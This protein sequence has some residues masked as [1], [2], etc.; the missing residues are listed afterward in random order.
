[1][2]KKSSKHAEKQTTKPET[3]LKPFFFFFFFTNTIMD[4]DNQLDDTD[5]CNSILSRFS[6]STDPQHHHLCSIIG[7]ISQTLKDLNHPLTP[8]AYFGATCTS[9]NKLLSSDPKPPSHHIDALVTIIS[10][11]L[12][13]IS[14]A[15]VRKEA[16]YVS[17]LITRVV[18]AN[19]VGDGVICSGLKC[20]SHLLIVGHRTSWD[21]VSHLFGV[22][23]GFVA[24]SRV[25]V[26]RQAHVCLRD[27]LQAF[28]ETSVLSP[29][30]EAIASTFERFLLLAGG[31]NT[32]PNPKEGSRAQEV[33]Y[34]LDSLKDILPLMSV[35]FSTKILN[36]FKSLLALHQSA[37][38]RRITDAL[39]LLCLQS[40]VDVSP[41]A[42]VDLL[43]SLATSVSSNEMSGDNL[44]FTA[45]LLDVGMKKV[46]SLNRQ[47]C[48]VKLPVV[49][50]AFTDILASEHEEPLLVA[51]EALKSLIY[52]CID[53]SL[54][55]QGVDQI[56]ASGSVRK[57][58]PT[59]IEKL[60]A[61]VESLLDYSF[62]AVWDMSFQVV[63][64]MFDKLGE[65]SSYFLKGALK[66][67]EGIQK[68]PDEDFSYR[69][70]LH[71]C[72]GVAV[73]ALGP[74]AF[75]KFLPLNVEAQDP[76][77]A[78][79]WLLP[80]LKQN[81]VG[82]RLSFFNESLLDSIRVLKLKSAKFEQEGRIHSARSVDGLVYSLWSLLPSFC[83]YPVDTA[84]SFKDLESELRHS[85]REESEFRGVVCSSLQI[86]I[87]QNKRILE[88]ETEAS[89][90]DNVSQQQAVSR[91]T[92]QVAAC[93]LDVLRSTARGI[94]STLSGIFMKSSKD[95]GGSLQITIREFASI[96]DKS[97]VS[98]L[99]KSTMKKL[100]KVT[101]E[102][103]KI[104]NTK[105]S[106]SMEIDNSSNETSLSLSRAK[107][108]DLAVA[109]L[110]G[111]GT[112]EV[113]LLFDAVKPALKDTE[114]LIQK[115]AY[116]VLSTILESDDSFIARKFEDLLMQM[117]EV[118]HS[119]HFSAK[120]HRLDCL[121]YLLA[122]VSKDKSEQMK[123]E[124]VASFLTE[125]VLGLK[126]SNKKTR[127]RAYEIIVQIGH[128]CVDEDKGG[129]KE[130][131]YNFF[132][133]V[134]GG[135]AGETPHMISATVKGIARLTYEFNDLLSNAFIVLPSTFLLLQRKS[136]EINKASLGFL[137]VLVA[138]SQTEGLQT[139]M[140]GMVEALL[141]WQ[142]SNKN[143]FKAK[144]KQLL[145]MLIKKC[146]LEAVKEVMPEEHMKLLTNIRK[147]NERKERKHSANTEETK[148]RLSKATTSR[149]SRWNHTKIFS[150]LGDEETENG[151]FEDMTYSGRQSMLNSKKSSLKSKRTKKRLAEDSYE[152]LDD[153]P[154]DLLDREK[155]RSSLRSSDSLKRKLQS[156]D[157]P[158]IDADGRLIITEDDRSFKKEITATGSDSDVRSVAS[159]K[160]EKRRKTS[161]SGWAYTGS[162]YTS[163]KAGGDLKRK[164]KF[165]PYAYWP[166]D[167][168]MVSR[169]PEQRAVARKGMSSVVKRLE[170]QTVSNALAMKG[171][172]VKRSKNKN[173]KKHG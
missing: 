107:L 15:V 101:Q 61:T 118:M 6:N 23:I 106:S 108:Y 67:L 148:S 149:L 150:D 139:H 5:F 55:K 43:C 164:G 45:R 167:R 152:Q 166:L 70:Q 78:N 136:K 60:C 145:E 96:A 133:M 12:P 80:I 151:N 41:D 120:R 159:R 147:I 110:P 89:A 161:Q 95:D 121:Y 160:K 16:E 156:D 30:S 53:E 105:G 57:S 83:N 155:T 28:Q 135:L 93:N 91:Y 114:S 68:L 98:S 9:L 117:F 17:G 119:C 112:E 141:S 79:V 97:V 21:D 40:T 169:R 11:L 140:R 29:A 39:Y 170:G 127:N 59:I 75:L 52:T 38:T 154:L 13:A 22:L 142:S 37:A 137:K 138:K 122:H 72:M 20:V 25:K 18:L 33:L 173:H 76:S 129:N 14:S 3:N 87:Q 4:H 36:Y 66:S 153:E 104:Q 34:V 31:S 131:L 126:E 65:F 165:E 111:L 81:I 157:E 85:L 123:R 128:A 143:H 56:R 54:I 134:A 171:L 10:M 130:N 158:E 86:L 62:A 48:V 27:V 124:V 64:A 113:D 73:V 32:N 8:L 77:D 35:K 109:L 115:K 116:K 94:L 90:K 49:F 1:M 100:L 172:K 71:D 24:D 46:F 82:A 88:G 84:E 47:S 125:I 103:G 92:S 19:D 51:M 42:L 50:S 99:F 7:D 69:K 168:K 63:A 74:E 26:R 58:A 162:D 144:V 44:T 163:K 146:G 132:N 2:G 102:A